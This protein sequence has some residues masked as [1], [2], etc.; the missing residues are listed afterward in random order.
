MPNNHTEQNKRKKYPFKI[1]DVDQ[2]FLKHGQR[3][4]LELSSRHVFTSFSK[5]EYT[6]FFPPNSN[7]L[8]FEVFCEVKVFNQDQNTPKNANKKNIT[9][10]HFAR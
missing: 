5:H 4:K 8:L 2:L 10:L 9:L 1:E 7:C 6:N 3:K